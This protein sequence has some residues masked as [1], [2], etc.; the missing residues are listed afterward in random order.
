MAKIFLIDLSTPRSL[1]H[2][3]N[4]IISA[5]NKN[6]NWVIQISYLILIAISTAKT[7]L[8]TCPHLSRSPVT[9]I[10][11]P[12]KKKLNFF[13]N[14]FSMIKN[15]LLSLLF[16]MGTNHQVAINKL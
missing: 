6:K 10:Q 11:S 13:L 8:L 7:F 15:F 12:T 2:D 14:C 5:K 16:P 4:L 1:S 3:L 9:L